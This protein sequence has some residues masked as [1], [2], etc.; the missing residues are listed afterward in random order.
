MSGLCYKTYKSLMWFLWKTNLKVTE[1]DIATEKRMTKYQTLGNKIWSSPVLV[2]WSLFDVTK[3]SFHYHFD[4]PYYD[5]D[6]SN[7][8]WILT[9]W[10][11]WSNRSIIIWF[12]LSGIT[13]HRLL[14][15]RKAKLAVQESFTTVPLPPQPELMRSLRLVTTSHHINSLQCLVRS[16]LVIMMVMWLSTTTAYQAPT[17]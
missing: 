13:L 7:I 4:D 17:L 11:M 16:S 15:P 3:T 8:Y 2:I 5:C 6:L 14:G 10:T 1:V 12:I 9:I